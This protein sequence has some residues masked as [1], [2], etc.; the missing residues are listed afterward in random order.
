MAAIGILA[1][2]LK[3]LAM[4]Y[5]DKLAKERKDNVPAKTL[6][7]LILASLGTVVSYAQAAVDKPAEALAPAASEFINGIPR[8]DFYFISGVIFFELLLILVLLFQIAS[9][10]RVLRNIPDRKPLVNRILSINLLDYFNKSVPVKEEHTIVMDHD[11]DGIHELDNSLPPWWKWGFIMTIVFAFGYM[12]YYHV[13]DGP[14]QV[15]EYTAAMKKGE[16]E[17]LAYLAKA[18]NTVDENNVTLIADA[19]QLSDARVLFKNTCSACH[20][21][22]GGGTVGPNL[23][24][25]YWLHGGTLKDVFKSIKYG[26]KDKGMPEWQHNMN[27]KQIAGIASYVKSLR[28]K[29]PAG[30][31]APQGEL[32]VE[33]SEKAA[34]STTNKSESSATPAALKTKSG[35]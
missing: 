11:Y 29:N 31:K 19:A 7:L 3:Q 28:G 10:V 6:L 20:R 4:A 33:G 27:A 35:Y 1:I 5:R 26:W 17:K 22:D 8:Y 2:V 16:E 25:D 15:A 24:D 18:G 34:D 14:D 13:A 12:W 30:A 9:L 23:T 32:L 21:D